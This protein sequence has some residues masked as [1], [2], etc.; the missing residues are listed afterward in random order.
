MY[1]EQSVAESVIKDV[2]RI[3]N[4]FNFIKILI[5]DDGSKDKTPVIISKYK[6]PRITIIT[7]KKRSGV[8]TCIYSGLEYAKIRDFTHFA[9][10]PGSSRVNSDDLRKLILTLLS[11][12]EDYIIGSRFLS[13]SEHSNTPFFRQFLICVTGM[14]ISHL[15]KRRITDITCGLRLFNIGKWDHTLNSFLIGSKYK[16][17]QMLT[18]WALH[19]HLTWKEVNIS[20]NYSPARPYSYVNI[21]NMHQIILPWCHYI[22]WSKSHINRLKPKWL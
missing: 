20:I 11:T 17:E 21:F 12:H 5:I 4:E 1:N 19:H 9:Y 15:I 18:I 3:V 13:T 6:T 16:G 22:L 2:E 7:H 8:G 14:L 10:M